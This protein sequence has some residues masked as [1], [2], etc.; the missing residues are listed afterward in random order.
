ML[1]RFIEEEIYDNS[2]LIE[3]DYVFVSESI[4]TYPSG[5][6]YLSYGQKLRCQSLDETY[7]Y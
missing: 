2:K 4:A 3:S 7:S 5:K 1:E 6:S